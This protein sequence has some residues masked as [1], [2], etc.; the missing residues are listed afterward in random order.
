MP[1]FLTILLHRFMYIYVYSFVAD[2]F[3]LFC[4]DLGNEVNDE[5]LSKAFSRFP[6]F[7]MARVSFLARDVLLWCDLALSFLL[8]LNLIIHSNLCV[9]LEVLCLPPTRCTW[10]LNFPLVREETK[11]AVF[12]VYVIPAMAYTDR[13]GYLEDLSSKVSR[14][15]LSLSRCLILL[16]YL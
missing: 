1:V 6:S 12:V 13:S 9:M 10:E 4:G 8:C 2:D 3:R 14:W 16:L 7:N 15:S 11:Y 5:V